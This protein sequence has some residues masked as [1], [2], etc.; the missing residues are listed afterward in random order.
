MKNMTIVPL[1]IPEFN[2]HYKEAL[3]YYS[4][5]QTA[6]GMILLEATPLGIFRATFVSD[7]ISL[8]GYQFMAIPDLKKVL[9]VGT[10]FQIKVW[11]AALEIPVGSTISYSN[12]AH[13]IGHPKAYR[14]V[15]TALGKNKVAYLVPCHRVLSQSGSWGGYA[16]G[17]E[18]K[19]AL[20]EAEKQMVS[21]L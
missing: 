19:V 16:W 18:K 14:A 12:M 17:V 8:E 10:P 21:A 13:K 1:T 5:Y 15:G 2:R 7:K 4:Y 6:A 3:L 11:R 9:L 20:L